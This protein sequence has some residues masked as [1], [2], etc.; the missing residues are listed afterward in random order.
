MPNDE[1]W[2]GLGM[3]LEIH[4]AAAFCHMFIAVKQWWLEAKIFVFSNHVYL[5]NCIPE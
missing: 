1:S 2:A 5:N 4:I 3:R